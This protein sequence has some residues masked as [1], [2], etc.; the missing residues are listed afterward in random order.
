MSDA[1]ELN[2]SLNKK[3]VK[4]KNDYAKEQG[5]LNWFH[6]QTKMKVTKSSLNHAIDEISKRLLLEFINEATQK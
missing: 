1:E 6:F 2:K 3:L 5:T 4:A